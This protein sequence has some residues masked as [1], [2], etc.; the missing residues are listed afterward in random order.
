MFYQIR[1]QGHLTPEWSDW[2][3]GLT[4]ENDEQGAVLSGRLADKAALYG[5]LNQIQALNLTLISVAPLPDSA[6]D[7]NPDSPPA[8]SQDS[9]LGE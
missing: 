3:G 1:I 4:I 9:P 6:G 8:I 7:E 5:V 2:F